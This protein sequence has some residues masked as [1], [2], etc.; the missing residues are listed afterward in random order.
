MIHWRVVYRYDNAYYRNK[1]DNDINDNNSYTYHADAWMTSI[2][3]IGTKTKHT[4]NHGGTDRYARVAN[5]DVLVAIN[6]SWCCQLYRGHNEGG[7]AN[8]TLD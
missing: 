3:V 5:D 7:S 6:S 4:Q 8:N 1:R 2:G